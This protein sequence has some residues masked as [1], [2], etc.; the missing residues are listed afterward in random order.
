MLARGDAAWSACVRVANCF[1]PRPACWRGATCLGNRSRIRQQ[2][3]NPRPACW[4]GA[5]TSGSP[6]VLHLVV[7]IRAPRVGAGRRGEDSACSDSIFGFNPRPACW[8]GATCARSR[9]VGNEIC[10]N[11]RPAC[12]RGATL[13]W[14]AAA[15]CEQVSIRAPRV[16]AGRRRLHDHV[17]H[18]PVVSIRAP[19]VGAGR[20]LVVVVLSPK[21]VFQS[22]PRVLARGDR[23]RVESIHIL[24]SF[25]P[26]PACWRGAT[27]PRGLSRIGVV[28]SIRAPRVGAG[29]HKLPAGARMSNRFQSAPR[30]LARGD[31]FS[32]KSPNCV[33]TFQS[34]PRVL[35]RGDLQCWCNA[36]AI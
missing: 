7:S 25:N 22:A 16:G 12:W 20:P 21:L 19:R 23:N 14:C 5:T 3:F 2:R 28:V 35:A 29:R 30:V 24:A 18:N 36:Q 27:V 9:P 4:R 8:R 15:R 11:P 10:F 26:R 33:R 13:T 6:S 1:N 34:A 32:T 31:S 17:V